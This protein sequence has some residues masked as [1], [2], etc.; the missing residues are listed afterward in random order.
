MET[1]CTVSEMKD[2]TREIRYSQEDLVPSIFIREQ[3]YVRVTEEKLLQIINAKSE[4]VQNILK[5]L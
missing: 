2:G 5:T 4:D 1:L 3:F